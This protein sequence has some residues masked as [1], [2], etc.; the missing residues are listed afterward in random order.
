MN[1]CLKENLKYIEQLPNGNWLVRYGV[2]PY[3]QTPDGKEMVIFA[4]SEYP[5]KPSIEQI[6]KSIHRYAM[7]HLGNEE[8][9]EGV[10]NPDMTAYQYVESDNFRLSQQKTIIFEE[11][12]E[13][14]DF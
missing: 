13:Y 11:G 14:E 8:I 6:R 7:A 2:V 10:A 5:Q 1:I 3:G 4:S 12:E 9:L